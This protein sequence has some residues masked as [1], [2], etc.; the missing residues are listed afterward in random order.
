[1]SE[2]KSIEMVGQPGTRQSIAL[3]LRRIGVDKGMTLIVHSSLSGMGWVNGGPVA[4]IKALMD[5]LTEKG[6]LAQPHA[7]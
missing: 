2:E 7:V 3:D 4:V 5:V 1:M 6:T